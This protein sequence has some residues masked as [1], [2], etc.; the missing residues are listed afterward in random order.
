MSAEP[1]PS[2]PTTSWLD[3]RRLHAYP[4][5]ILA[6][7][8]LG[9]ALAVALGASAGPRTGLIAGDFPALYGAGRVVASG[10]ATR[11][12]DAVAQARAQ[13]DLLP[14]ERGASGYM[15]FAYPPYVA[16]MYRPLAAL[17]YRVAYV[18]HTL[19]MA[20]A[21]LAAAWSLGGLSPRVRRY[22]FEGF[23]M[24][25]AFVPMFIALCSA[26]LTPLL[27]LALSLGLLASTRGH[28]RLAGLCLGALWIEPQYALPLIALFVLARPRM[29]VPALI[30]AVL[31]Y[32]AGVWLQGWAWPAT[33][34]QQVRLHHADRHLDALH[35]VGLLGVSEAWLGAGTWRA[36]AVGCATMALCAVVLWR[37]FR[38]TRSLDLRIAATLPLVVL[39][40]PHA[41]YHDAGLLIPSF[42]VV[43]GAL[44][45]A[46][47]WPLGAIFVSG[48]LA[49]LGETLRVSPAFITVLASAVVCVRAARRVDQNRAA[50]P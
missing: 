46:A 34:L 35:S 50:A 28:D 45:R 13:A 39:L 10:E 29:V 9:L 47:L 2:S 31:A 8:G 1:T 36:I 6:G 23:A 19:G 17:P 16:L 12:Y 20:A 49:P 38:G 11:L 30:A 41:M 5:A 48:M 27:V 3:A 4:R 22:A 25:V 43:A 37:V 42:A 21:L 32:A 40:E 7:L 44:G 33:Y 24:S 14:G 15:A 26:Q 18:L